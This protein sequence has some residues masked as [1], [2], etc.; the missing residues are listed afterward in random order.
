MK[1]K[2]REFDGVEAGCMQQGKIPIFPFIQH[3]L[4][5]MRQISYKEPTARRR[6][7]HPKRFI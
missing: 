7:M 3:S 2:S 5:G 6:D 4:Q 1:K